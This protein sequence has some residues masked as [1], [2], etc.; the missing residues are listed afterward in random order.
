MLN[1]TAYRYLTACLFICLAI[2]TPNM[3]MAGNNVFRKF[4]NTDNLLDNAPLCALRDKYGFLW[5]GTTTGLNC[6]DGNGASVYRN[7]AGIYQS[8]ATD[9][10]NILY[11]YGDD[12]WFSGTSGLYVFNRKSNT[13]GQLPYKT[14]YGVQISSV[15]QNIVTASNGTVWICTQGQGLFVLNPSDSSFQQDSRHGIFFSDMT[16][17]S[18]G[19]V[20]AVSLTGIISAFRPDG[21][22]VYSCELPDYVADKNK[23]CMASSGNEIWLSL[24]TGLYCLDT[25]TRSVVCKNWHAVPDIITS[26]LTGNDGRLLLGT[27][28]GVWQYA[29]E[30]GTATRLDPVGTYAYGLADHNINDLC[31][32]KDGSLIVVTSTGIGYMPF[33]SDAF[34]FTSLP[35][36]MRNGSCNYVRALF[37]LCRQNRR[38]GRYRQRSCIL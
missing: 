4:A 1:T 9:N 25:R 14:K 26:L 37:P 38:V 8:K 21:T 22:F 31:W 36:S 18:D 20:Y 23:I 17:G 5:V 12:I 3:S 28:D 19:L 16:V 7:S 15:V 24:N 35:Q 13:V 33:E 32:D 34:G 10:V 11:E 27:A 6:F 30:T 29:T 2:S